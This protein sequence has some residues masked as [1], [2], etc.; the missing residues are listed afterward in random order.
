MKALW[1][2]DLD[3][4]LVTSNIDYSYVLMDFARLMLSV[5]GRDN[6]RELAILD[7]TTLMLSALE[8]KAPY[9][10]EIIN[11]LNERIE[12]NTFTGVTPQDCFSGIL[13]STYRELH[14][15]S[16]VSGG[17]EFRN[18]CLDIVASAFP[19]GAQSISLESELKNPF[20]QQVLNL[21]HG[22][23][24]ERFKTMRAH[25]DRFPGS[26]VEAYKELCRRDGAKADPAVERQVWKIGAG[27]LSEETYQ[28][29]SMI[30]GAWEVLSWL[31]IRQHPL[32]CGT[33]GDRQ[34]QWMKWRGYNL[35]RFFPTQR[36]FR[37]VK[38][39]KLDTLKAIR[40]LQPDVPTFMVGDSVGSDL[41][42]A[43]K[44]G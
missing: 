35:G 6:P 4:T 44:P 3:G 29:R 30:P 19:A 20:F 8:H 43:E 41:V 33:A 34:V 5:F 23:D 2:F 39:G 11:L 14:R 32:Y 18:V 7:F 16:G 17:M 28:N 22:I 21:E 12:E 37:P 15:R 36:E 27:A 38:R 26:L 25:R 9:Y 10:Q 24:R 13:T 40:S 1:V 31:K 42:P